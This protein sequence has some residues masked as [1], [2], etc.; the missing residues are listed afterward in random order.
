MVLKHTHTI[1]HNW[2]C[3][4][5]LETSLNPSAKQWHFDCWVFELLSL[6]PVIHFPACSELIWELGKT[7]VNDHLDSLKNK[8]TVT[9]MCQCIDTTMS[10]L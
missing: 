1:C 3:G 5:D 2:G 6:R 4:A 7:E 8:L 9:V 10:S